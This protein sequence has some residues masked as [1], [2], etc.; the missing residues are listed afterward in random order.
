MIFMRFLFFITSCFT[1]LKLSELQ[2]VFM[3][4]HIG[5]ATDDTRASMGFRA[6]DNLDQFFAGNTPQ[7]L[8]N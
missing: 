5:S 3:L 7:D 6:L 4:P 2:Q 8:L 1:K